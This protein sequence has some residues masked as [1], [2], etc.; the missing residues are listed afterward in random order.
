MALFDWS[1][2]I[3][4]PYSAII[5]KLGDIYVARIPERGLEYMDTD[6]NKVIQQTINVLPNGGKIFIKKGVYE[7]GHLDLTGKHGITIEGEVEGSRAGDWGTTLKLKAGTN[8]TMFYKYEST[9]DFYGFTLRNLYLDGNKENQTDGSA[10]KIVRTKHVRIENCWI[11]N[12]YKHGIELDSSDVSWITNCDIRDNGSNGLAIASN[13]VYVDSTT[14]G[15]SGNYNVYIYGDYRNINFIGCSFYLASMDNVYIQNAVNGINFIGCSIWNGGNNGIWL[16][17]STGV[18]IM[19]GIVKNNGQAGNAGNDNGIKISGGGGHKIIGVNIFD[20]QATKTQ[21]YGIYLYSEDYDVII[22]NDLRNNKTDSV[23]G[24]KGEHTSLFGNK[25]YVTENSGKATF[26]GD[27]TTTQ[28]SIAHGLVSTPSKVIVTP[29]S[30]D[31][32][33]DFYVT[34]DATNIYVNYVTAPAS[35]TDNVVLYWYAEV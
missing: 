31:A 8:D 23:Y 16:R 6:A 15:G 2:D 28:F 4:T 34:V 19:G 17:D 22:Y 20:E 26:S 21:S 9:T 25:G 10:I 12:F 33:G 1:F 5:Y 3:D 11:G 35:G 7:I 13:S 14:V 24:T 32:S 27:G 30:A 18:S 29:S